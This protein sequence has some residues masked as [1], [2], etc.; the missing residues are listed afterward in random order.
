MAR[1]EHSKFADSIRITQK[2]LQSLQMLELCG[3]PGPMVV[4]PA[5][6]Q[7]FELMPGLEV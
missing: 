1:S 2:Y 4:Y 7:T 6:S 5:K 3:T